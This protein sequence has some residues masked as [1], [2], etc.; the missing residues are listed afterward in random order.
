M[1]G[2]GALALASLIIGISSC[3]QKNTSQSEEVQYATSVQESILEENPPMAGFDEKNSD[4]EAIAIADEVMK[5]M[6]GRQNWD[7]TRYISWNFFGARQLIWDKWKGDVR[8]EYPKKDLKI[9]VNIHNLKGRVWKGTEEVTQSDSLAKY[10]QKGKSIWIN[11]S[12]WLCLP[13]KLKDSGLTLKYMGEREDQEENAIDDVL[14]LTFDK[15]GDTPQNKYRVYV[16]RENHLVSA[17][18]YFPN[19][20]DKEASFSTPWKDYQQYGKILLS[21]NRGEKELK[22]IRVFKELP[23][24]VFTSF[25]E[26]DLSLYE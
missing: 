3:Q 17:W 24:S 19:T 14:E 18:E 20:T 10:L 9:L 12:Y 8:I 15:V 13:F 5:A 6:G 21:G 4:Q 25:E 26:L 11:D 7:E 1:R 2:I 22:D 16:D 23:E